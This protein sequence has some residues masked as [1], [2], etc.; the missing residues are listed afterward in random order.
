MRRARVAWLETGSGIA[1][2]APLSG[3]AR[4]SSTERRDLAPSAEPAACR[5][6][7]SRAPGWARDHP[8]SDRRLG[9]HGLRRCSPRSKRSRL[10]VRPFRR[11]SPSHR[12][13]RPA[14]IRWSSSTWFAMGPPARPR[15]T[16]TPSFARSPEPTRRR[17]A[18]CCR[19]SVPSLRAGGAA[20]HI[21]RSRSRAP[22]RP[23]TASGESRASTASRASA[24]VRGDQIFLA[25]GLLAVDRDLLDLQR[26]GKR[27]LFRV[28]ACERGLDLGRNPL[29]QLLGGLG[30]DLLHE[31]GEQPA[32]D[33]PGHAEGTVELGRPAVEPAVDVYLLVRGRSVAA[34]FL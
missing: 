21:R 31:G 7:P 32:A 33:A 11:K 12:A 9:A 28:G 19:R 16:T 14:W 25:R 13:R 23:P 27:D 30:P 24:L 18:M 4:S 26:A 17:Q 20:G 34:V 6:S 1:S 22:Q 10:V 5:R 8:A 15:E 29:A 2:A 3:P